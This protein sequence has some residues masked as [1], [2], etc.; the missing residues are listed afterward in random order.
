MNIKNIF[1]EDLFTKNPTFVLLLGMCPSL[2][3]TTSIDNAIGMTIAVTLVLMIT[4]LVV[5]LIRKFIPTEVRI[6]VYI[7]IIATFVSCIT[8]LTEAYAYPL[9]EALGIF[10]P[11]ITVNCIVLGRAEAFASRNKV[12]HSVLDGLFSGL[13]FG[14]G[15][16][17]ISF[18]C[19]K[20]FASLNKV[21]E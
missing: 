16:L 7:I 4:N 21:G 10:L 19:L 11:L 13:G 14:I 1:K 17:S 18:K 3:I 6:P 5:S 15:I 12:G 8:M 2:A 20:A 9:Y